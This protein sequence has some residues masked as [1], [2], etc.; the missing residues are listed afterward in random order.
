MIRLY[1][2][3]FSFMSFH[4]VLSWAKPMETKGMSSISQTSPEHNR[5]VPST[6][7]RFKW[8]DGI[9]ILLVLA[10]TTLTFPAFGTLTPSCTEVFMD[11]KLI[12]TYPLDQDRTFTVNGRSGPVR[13]TIKNHAVSV[14]HAT[15]P[16]G[17][18]RK[19][20]SVSKPHTQ[21]VCAPNHILV[22]ITSNRPDTLDAV[23][24]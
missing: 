23:A 8:G 1:G 16:R 4:C 18:C 5:E 10:A 13:I 22:T 21:I 12:A 20:G 7:Y 14:E 17:I 3:R 2:N 15:C 11:N 24:R 9:L 6:L 19:T